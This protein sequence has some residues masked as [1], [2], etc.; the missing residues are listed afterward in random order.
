MK[1]KEL[2]IVGERKG[3]EVASWESTDSKWQVRR[4]T[5]SNQV[6]TKI[7]KMQR[8]ANKKVQYNPLFE[9]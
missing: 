4:I 3:K 6:R 5:G 1:W 7:R 2:K 9:G 8:P